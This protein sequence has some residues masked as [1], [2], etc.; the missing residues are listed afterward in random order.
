MITFESSSLQRIN[1]LQF[2]TRLKLF[3]HRLRSCSNWSH[4]FTVIGNGLKVIQVWAVLNTLLQNWQQICFTAN[5]LKFAVTAPAVCMIYQCT[6]FQTKKKNQQNWTNFHPFR[7]TSRLSYVM[8]TF[9]VQNNSWCICSWLNI[10]FKSDICQKRVVKVVSSRLEKAQIA[11][12]RSL[13]SEVRC[14]R[15][16]ISCE[17]IE[18]CF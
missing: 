17:K 18:V 13:L 1:R 10:L 9:Q 4:K 11:F 5:L 8:T 16:R 3:L 15:G 12:G 6:S 7:L 14:E 2:C